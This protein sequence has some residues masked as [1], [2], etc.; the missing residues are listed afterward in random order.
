MSVRTI[1]ALELVFAICAAVG[2]AIYGRSYWAAWFCIFLFFILYAWR[3]LK[4]GIYYTAYSE[5]GFK[6]TRKT[7]P[8]HFYCGVDAQL[9]LALVSLIMFLCSL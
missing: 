5:Y 3:C 7:S 6:F 2:F 9:I 1:Q 8:V 4:I